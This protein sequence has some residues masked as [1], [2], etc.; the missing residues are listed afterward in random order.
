VEV[1][2][3]LEG[4]EKQSLDLGADHRWGAQ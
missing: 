2:T 3:L 4:F 1:G